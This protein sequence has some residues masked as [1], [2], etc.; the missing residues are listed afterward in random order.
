MT[1][2]TTPHLLI[3]DHPA[4]DFLNTAQRGGAVER[5]TALPDLLSWLEQTGLL[6]PSAI[7]QFTKNV[8]PADYTALVSK[9][10][11][12]REWLRRFVKLHAGSRLSRDV[13]REL[14]PLNQALAQ[15]E[16]RR[17]IDRAPEDVATPELCWKLCAPENDPKYMLQPI[18]AS[19][20][21]L[22]CETDFT[23]VRQ[24]EGIGCTLWFLDTSQN[25]TR[26]W[27]SMAQCGNRSKAAAHRARLRN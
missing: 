13:L 12:H 23:R 4:L 20:G 22:V 11:E 19:F 7:Q 9:A 15:F 2:P 25:G 27:C 1:D 8:L 3:A 26:R 14:Q 16:V 10:R 24:C 18:V 21:D 17:Q 5:L 6:F